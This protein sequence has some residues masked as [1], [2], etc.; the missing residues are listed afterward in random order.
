MQRITCVLAL[1]LLAQFAHA[2]SGTTTAALDPA[3]LRAR[4]Q[5]ATE[6][7]RAKEPP[8]QFEE[9][10]RSFMGPVI[11]QMNA[12]M[13]KRGHKVSL[14]PQRMQRVIMEA[15]PY[16]EYVALLAE[17][18]AKRLTLDELGQITSFYKSA[19]GQKLLL[20]EQQVFVETTVAMMPTMLSR[21]DKAMEKERLAIPERTRPP[22]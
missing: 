12:E 18:Y 15:M 13:A 9:R 5:A 17:A 21:I 11:A 1:V 8:E 16:E 10:I 6:M 7:V 2:Q 3:E 19:A 14:D 20:A 4:R 22:Q